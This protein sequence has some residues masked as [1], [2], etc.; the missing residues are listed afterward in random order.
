MIIRAAFLCDH[1]SVRDNV[2]FA[3]AAGVTRTRQDSFPAPNPFMLALLLEL[4]E[5]E[6]DKE[7]SIQLGIAA[8]GENPFAQVRVMLTVRQG[9]HPMMVPLS[10]SMSNVAIEKPGNYQVSIVINA[11]NDLIPPLSFVVEKKS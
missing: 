2:L 1:A 6:T 11:D 9:L 3:V 8:Q 7:H 5:S 10:V 4:D